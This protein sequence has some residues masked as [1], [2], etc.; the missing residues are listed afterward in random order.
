M[1]SPEQR[2][3]AAERFA[4]W[5]NLQEPQRRELRQRYRWF[6]EQPPERQRQLRRVFQRFRHLPPEERRALMRRFESMTDQQRQG[7]I[8]GV[9][10]NERANGMRRFLERFSQ[11]ERQQLRRI[12]Q[13][14][15]DEQ[16]MIFRHRVRSTPPDQR[17][18]LMRQWLQMSDRERTE[19]LQPR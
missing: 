6:R 2:A 11:E 14:L 18:Q 7:F 10:M 5:Q 13:S 9:R 17:E 8:E 15:S 3:Q 12:D 16:R 1:V 4:R 19:Y